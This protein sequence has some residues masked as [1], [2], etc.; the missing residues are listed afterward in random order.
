M[1]DVW[2]YH[3]KTGRTGLLVDFE[4]WPPPGWD[5]RPAE[6]SPEEWEAQFY[7]RVAYSADRYQDGRPREG[8][9]KW[10]STDRLRPASLDEINAARPMRRAA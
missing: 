10:V 4:Q 9:I 6:C 1:L 2:V 3:L 7:L 5:K 8:G